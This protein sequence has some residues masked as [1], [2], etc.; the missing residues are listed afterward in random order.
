MNT[1]RISG[2]YELWKT[3]ELPREA[4]SRIVLAETTEQAIDMCKREYQKAE[5]ISTLLRDEDIL[6]PNPP[7]QEANDANV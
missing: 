7:E 2:R 3:D 1:Y 4:F 5:I 6:M